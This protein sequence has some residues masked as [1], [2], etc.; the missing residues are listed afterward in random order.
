GFA[1]RPTE[2]RRMS[3]P[4]WLTEAR[5]LRADL[6]ALLAGALAAL[7]LP[8]LHVLPVLLVAFPVLLALIRASGRSIVAARR[9]WWV[10]FGYRLVG[11]YW[12]TEAILF[13]AARFW[14][15]VPLAVP[16]L[17]AVLA[18]FVAAASLAAWWPSGVRTR[19]VA[20][21]RSPEQGAKPSGGSQGG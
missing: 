2:R 16:A 12:V 17:A 3:F 5:G 14:W 10:G 21:P 15:L 13:E 20:S 11:L 4:G 9:G 7:A 1:T 6:I 8:P 18:L 19:R